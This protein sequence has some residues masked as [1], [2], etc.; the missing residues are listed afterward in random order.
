MDKSPGRAYSGPPTEPDGSFSQVEGETQETAPEAGPAEAPAPKRTLG[1]GRVR[2]GAVIAIVIAGGLL[3]WLLTRGGNDT[4][5]SPPTQ[6]IHAGQTL[7]GYPPGAHVG[8]EI[9][10]PGKLAYVQRALHQPV[11]WLGT[12]TGRRIE[13]EKM[14]NGNVFLAYL[15]AGVNSSGDRTKYLVI[16]TYPVRDATKGLKAVAK[17]VGGEILDR[18]DGAIVLITPKHP[19]S[20]FIAY[21]KANFEVEIYSPNAQEARTLAQSDKLQLIG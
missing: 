5:S 21:P 3:A 16:G 13:F 1:T 4:S 9:D 17:A 7:P 14:P 8:P 15:P 10:S 19:K 20:A 6:T 11:Y 18:K 12:Q 2:I